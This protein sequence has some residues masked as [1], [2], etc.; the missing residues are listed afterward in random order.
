M[1]CRLVYRK[2]VDLLTSVI[3]KVCAAHPTVRFLI[4][5]DGPKKV[6]LE[7]MRDEQ[8]LHDRMEMTGSVASEDARNVSDDRAGMAMMG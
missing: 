2:G 6:D 5:G 7:Q 8:L 4:A 1:L 3:P